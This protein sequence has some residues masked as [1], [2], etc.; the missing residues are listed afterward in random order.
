[1][2]RCITIYLIVIC[3][4][5]SV[6]W[7]D[8]YT[9]NNYCQVPITTEKG[10]LWKK[11]KWW[12]VLKEAGPISNEINYALFYNDGESE[13]VIETSKSNH[14]GVGFKKFI[15]KVNHEDC[16]TPD[17][18]NNQ[19]FQTW[20]HDGS[21]IQEKK[22]NFEK[23]TFSQGFSRAHAKYLISHD[24]KFHGFIMDHSLP[25]PHDDGVFGTSTST[26]PSQH[27]FCFNFEESDYDKIVKLFQVSMPMIVKT[28]GDKVCTKHSSPLWF[29]YNPKKQ[30]FPQNKHLIYKFTRDCKIAMEKRALVE[31]ENDDEPIRK[32]FLDVMQSDYPD[33]CYKTLTFSNDIKAY[34]FAPRSQSEPHN[35]FN[36]AK[37]IFPFSETTPNGKAGQGAEYY[38]SWKEKFFN[39]ICTENEKQNHYNNNE[40]DTHLCSPVEFGI[41][42][43]LAVSQLEK[44]IFLVSTQNQNHKLPSLIKTSDKME[45]G[46]VDINS[47]FDTTSRHEKVGVE[48]ADRNQQSNEEATRVCIG[49]SNRVQGQL[50]H[51]GNIFCLDDKNLANALRK[52]IYTEKKKVTKRFNTINLYS[53]NTNFKFLDSDFTR[54]EQKTNSD[55]SVIE[56]ISGSIP[57][58]TGSGA[59]SSGTKKSSSSSDSRYPSFFYPNAQVN[60]KK[61]SSLA[62]KDQFPTC[63]LYKLNPTEVK[64]YLKK[65][66]KGSKMTRTD[67]CKPLFKTH[68]NEERQ[69]VTINEIYSELKGLKENDEDPSIWE[70]DVYTPASMEQKWEWIDQLYRAFRTRVFNKSNNSQRLQSYDGKRFYHYYI[71]NL[72]NFYHSFIN[73]KTLER[74]KEEVGR[75]EVKSYP[76]NSFRT[77]IQ[78]WAETNYNDGFKNLHPFKMSEVEDVFLERI[79]KVM[80]NPIPNYYT[81]T[82][83]Q[84][85]MIDLTFGMETDTTIKMVTE[86]CNAKPPQ[87]SE[88]Q[89]NSKKRGRTNSMQED[90]QNFEPHYKKPKLDSKTSEVHP[91]ATT[92]QA[93]PS[94]KKPEH[95]DPSEPSVSDE[96][97]K[98]KEYD[99]STSSSAPS[100]S[101]AP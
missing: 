44:K 13:T 20:Y 25:I 69:A 41:D 56:P 83:F 1:M 29:N 75:K 7:A 33:K 100:S 40:K 98:C 45:W 10:L 6:C 43:W 74:F 96:T 87:C 35:C 8:D 23:P 21:H 58:A 15:E 26:N 37:S 90:E 46:V 48:Y 59:S 2:N 47:F 3:I 76:F 51:L 81:E 101:S 70:E 67:Y 95:L 9:F 64:D 62:D 79:E 14:H 19:F 49:D 68:V 50:H 54:M 84:T 27:A 99:P 89:I 22:D 72:V 4:F 61:V 86:N 16:K 36:S 85:P 71:V 66:S 94:A 28:N 77:Y 82:C 60:P 11:V 34:G 17:A 24:K 57:P 78:C 5:I 93:H 65:S 80:M 12:M 18:N 91:P 31:T 32:H 73:L 88:K 42:S 38:Y 53:T 55:P 30:I 63:G 39:E 97:T 92:S 52:M